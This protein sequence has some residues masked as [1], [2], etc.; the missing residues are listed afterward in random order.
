MLQ[1]DSGG[2]GAAG[3]SAWELEGK[4][5]DE[6]VTELSDR[7]HAK[8]ACSDQLC[9]LWSLHTG[10]VGRW[11]CCSWV[12]SSD[13]PLLLLLLLLA[14]HAVRSALLP[15]GTSPAA[16]LAVLHV[17]VMS[18]PQVAPWQFMLATPSDA[19]MVTAAGMATGPVATA[20]Q[21]TAATVTGAAGAAK[22]SAR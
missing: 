12:S 16:G 7:L 14:R 21:A 8:L 10:V 13:P 22:P 11:A 18:W 19:V 9:S 20:A 1:G 15:L 2:L 3:S 4:D 5:E 17:N 6:S